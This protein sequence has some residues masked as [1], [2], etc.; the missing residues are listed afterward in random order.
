MYE[1]IRE[2]ALLTDE[3]IEYALRNYKYFLYDNRGNRYEGNWAN[4]RSVIQAQ[5]DKFLKTDGI[6]IEA[7]D[8]SLPYIPEREWGKLPAI[9]YGQKGM[10]TPDSEGSVWVKCLKEGKK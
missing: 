10:L 3:E 4:I 2:K 6:R 8:Q 1:R 5:I 9:R 7:D